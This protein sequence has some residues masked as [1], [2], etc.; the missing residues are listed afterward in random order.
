MILNDPNNPSRI[1]RIIPQ[2]EGCVPLAL[3][4]APMQSSEREL[5]CSGLAS[6]RDIDQ[7]FVK[8]AFLPVTRKASTIVC[9]KQRLVAAAGLVGML[10]QWSA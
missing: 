9:Q 1:I 7:C 2:K 6:D 5:D 3:T 8:R 4:K 10:I